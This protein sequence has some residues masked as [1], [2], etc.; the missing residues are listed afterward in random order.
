MHHTVKRDQKQVFTRNGR[1][2]WYPLTLNAVRGSGAI[3]RN[4]DTVLGLHTAKD[5]QGIFE[6]VL[7]KQK[8]GALGNK[9]RF[10]RVPAP[11]DRIDQYGNPE[12]S[13]VLIPA[14]PISQR[15]VE[16]TESAEQEERRAV[17]RQMAIKVVDSLRFLGGSCTSKEAV[18]A[19]MSGKT[20][21]KRAA[22]SAAMS[23]EWVRDVGRPNSHH[24]ELTEEAPV[25]D[26][27]P[28]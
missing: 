16:E 22:F 2:R 10:Q 28:K 23:W 12:T 18:Y 24:Y 11:T 25:S 27:A 3:T 15:S 6:L 9:V 19:L 21:R 8:D 7:L 1:E 17:Q 13:C 26:E 14:P 5:D 4:V 20:S